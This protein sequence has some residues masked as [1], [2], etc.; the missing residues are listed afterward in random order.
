MS[1]TFVISSS[2]IGV[3]LIMGSV[4]P[5]P[6]ESVTDIVRLRFAI[7]AVLGGGISVIL[8]LVIGVMVG[9]SLIFF[10]SLISLLPM[11]SELIKSS[12]VLGS[13]FLAGLLL[14]GGLFWEIGK[15]SSSLDELLSLIICL[16]YTSFFN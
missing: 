8:S 2:T 13:L 4:M 9:C 12:S 5:S 7:V 14:I 1:D 15:V 10:R 11:V 16:G 6:F 3:S